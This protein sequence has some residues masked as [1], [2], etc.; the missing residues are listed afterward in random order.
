[1]STISAGYAQD[2]PISKTI[3]TTISGVE[4]EGLISCSLYNI[5]TTI[6]QPFKNISQ[7]WHIPYFA[8]GHITYHDKH[9]DWRA[10]ESLKD[11][12]RVAEYLLR[13]EEMLKRKYKELEERKSEISEGRISESEFKLKRRSMRQQ[14][15]CGDISGPVYQR[16]LG[17]MRREA[18]AL[19]KR[20][21]KLED[22]F[23]EAYFPM[24]VFGS[25]R[26]SVIDILD[27]KK[28]FL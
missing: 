25:M 12:Y 22:S 19:Q 17:S 16:R 10:Q 23:F 15:K 18:E 5:E 24:S 28:L 7:S 26:E 1:M 8:R 14:L 21:W 4:V 20:I 3:Q 2:F 27:A 9:G 11:I 6:I 13:K